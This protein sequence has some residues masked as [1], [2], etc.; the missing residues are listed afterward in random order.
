[1][2]GPQPNGL[3]S[4]LAR[5]RGR[6]FELL[7]AQRA[8]PPPEAPGAKR[9][10]KSKAEKKAAKAKA[11]A[12]AAPHVAANDR[13]ARAGAGAVPTWW[14]PGWEKNTKGPATGGKQGYC[15]GFHGKSGCA[16]TKCPYSHLCP[17][18]VAGKQCNGKHPVSSAAI[19]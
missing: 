13:A 11:A 16:R 17:K 12:A 2:V 14:Q 4:H 7:L 1:M 10:K 19:E 3:D 15:H 6:S 9:Q 8:P 18:I 5:H